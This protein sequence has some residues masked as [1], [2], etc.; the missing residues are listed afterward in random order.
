MSQESK[1]YTDKAEKYLNEAK[2]TYDN[3]YS[4]Q[5]VMREERKQTLILSSIAASLIALSKK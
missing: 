5:T 3:R 4:N 2:Q 1:L